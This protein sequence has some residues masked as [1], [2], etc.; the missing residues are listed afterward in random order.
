MHRHVTELQG[1]RGGAALTQIPQMS[2][3]KLQ[4]GRGE[5]TDLSSA[6]A[7]KIYTTDVSRDISV[8]NQTNMYLNDSMSE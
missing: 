1:C 4:G 8:H 2:I 7:L 5:G 3:D 6:A